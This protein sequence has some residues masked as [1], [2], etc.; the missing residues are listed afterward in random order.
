MDGKAWG[1]E[2]VDMIQ[3]DIRQSGHP[4]P[5]ITQGGTP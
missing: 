1:I 2:N 4:V 3:F 5:L